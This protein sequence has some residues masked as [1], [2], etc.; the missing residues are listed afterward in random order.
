MLEMLDLKRKLPSQVYKEKIHPL[1]LHLNELQRRTFRAGVPTCIVFEGWDA[2]GKGTNIA[3]LA[4]RLDP[5]GFRVNAIH[6]PDRE[7]L[8]RPFLWRFWIRLPEHGHIAIF[9]R[10]W[11]GRVLVERVEKLTPVRDW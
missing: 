1:R 3:A 6:A 2:A 10:S 5:R 9:D 4:E 7:E 8:L 11:Y